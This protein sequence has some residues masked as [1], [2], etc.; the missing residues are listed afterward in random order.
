MLQQTQVVTVL[1][2]YRRFLERF[3]D[4]RS[5]AA[6]DERE[7]LKTWEGLG[8]YRRA[9]QMHAAAK[10]LVE[11][12]QGSFPDAFEDVLALPGIGRYTAGAICSFAFDQSTPIVEA[13]TQRLYARLLKLRQ[14]LDSKT[15]QAALWFFAEKI[16]PK[17]DARIINHATMELGAL[18]CTPKPKC[19]VCPLSSLCPTYKAELQSSIPVPKK[20]MEYE[21]RFEIA[22][23]ARDRKGRFRMRRYADG[24]WWSGLWDFPR[25]EIQPPSESTPARA[26][27]D[28]NGTLQTIGQDRFKLQGKLFSI[29]YGVTKYRITSTCFLAQTISTSKTARNSARWMT[30]DEIAAL[31]MNASGRKIADRLLKMEMGQDRQAGQAKRR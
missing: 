4:I 22:V 1:P 2:Y 18:V 7:V 10:Q 16:L 12:H 14:P 3:P 6:A 23:I 13:N 21:A 17:A 9:R 20:K 26:G 29:K 15:G 27:D 11:V 25:F 5:L 30:G 24:E 8:Y 28:L 19:E 31:P